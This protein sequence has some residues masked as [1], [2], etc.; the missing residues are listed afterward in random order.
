[1]TTIPAPAAHVSGAMRVLTGIVVPCGN[2]WFGVTTIAATRPSR[3]E[4]RPMSSPVETSK[5]MSSRSDIASRA[6]GEA[7]VLHPDRAGQT[8]GEE[9]PQ[10]VARA[11]GDDEV[12]RVDAHPPEQTEMIGDRPAGTRLSERIGRARVDVES[13]PP[14]PAERGIAQWV[15][16]AV[17]GAQIDEPPRRSPGHRGRCGGL[18]PPRQSR[19]EVGVDDRRRPFP[20]EEVALDRELGIRGLDRPAG[21]AEVAGELPT[22]R[23]GLSRP[24]PAR[25]EV[26]DPGDDLVG[27]RR[28]RGRVR[29]RGT[30]GSSAEVRAWLHATH[31]WPKLLDGFWLSRWATLSSS[32]EGTRR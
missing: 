31:Y 15:V 25:D 27:R 26:P 9:R 23:H 30:H 20:R 18:R 6:P 29:C 13:I 11:A 21:D 32:L 28:G 19:R 1:M 14:G 22:R 7:G 5:G 24:R 8:R 12:V 16:A 4:S 10:S 3:S 2:W 17:T